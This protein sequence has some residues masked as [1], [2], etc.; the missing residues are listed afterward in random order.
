MSETSIDEIISSAAEDV[1]NAL[2]RVQMR[3]I[4]YEHCLNDAMRLSQLE[5]AHKQRQ[6]IKAI[7]S[8]VYEVKKGSESQK[9]REEKKW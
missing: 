7:F 9:K 4:A 6:Q 8:D 5:N 2:V 1:C 3:W